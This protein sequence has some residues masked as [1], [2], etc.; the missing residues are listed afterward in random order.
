MSVELSRRQDHVK[1]WVRLPEFWCE[2]EFDLR[3]NVRCGVA[4]IGPTG[5]G[6]KIAKIVQKLG[7]KP[8][9]GC[10]KRRAALNKLWPSQ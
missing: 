3:G 6:D 7:F 9:G 1:I 8:C 10:R 2:V 4:K 5:L